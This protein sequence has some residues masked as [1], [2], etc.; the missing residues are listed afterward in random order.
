[1]DDF[2]LRDLLSPPLRFRAEWTDKNPVRNNTNNHN[3]RSS[4]DPMVL[5]MAYVP[6]QVWQDLYEPEDG[7]HR[8]TIF[9]QL[10]LPFEGGRRQ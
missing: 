9:R 7:F 3:S 2:D 10:D 8:G 4:G 1:M 6:N 5:A